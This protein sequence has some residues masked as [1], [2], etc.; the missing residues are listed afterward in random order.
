MASE[1]GVGHRE[2]MDVEEL[3][4]AFQ[5]HLALERSTSPHTRRAYRGDIESFFGYLDGHAPASPA[6]LSIATGSTG[7]PFDGFGANYC[8]GTETPVTPYMLE[9]MKLAW[10]RHEL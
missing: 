7:Y 9:T 4:D 8:W 5:R 10:A 3:L 2:V 6:T 1:A